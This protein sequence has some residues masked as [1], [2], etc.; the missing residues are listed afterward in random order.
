MTQSRTATIQIA[1]YKISA[2]EL[3]LALAMPTYRQMA[4]EITCTRLSAPG[5]HLLLTTAYG[6]ALQDRGG[7]ITLVTEG[8][9]PQARTTLIRA[10]IR[11]CALKGAVSLT[12]QDGDVDLLKDI[13]A[14]ADKLGLNQKLPPGIPAGD[15]ALEAPSAIHVMKSL[16]LPFVRNPAWR[17]RTPE[18]TEDA[19]ARKRLEALVAS[20]RGPLCLTGRGLRIK[21]DG[22]FSKV[23]GTADPA[24]EW[25]RAG[26]GQTALDDG[27][28]DQII[29]DAE[30]EHAG[31]P[32]TP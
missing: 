30:I 24:N 5:D 17:A 1:A 16:Y 4:A 7:S 25:R 19:P 29:E 26:I 15:K 12:P 9:S 28:M 31:I 22:D 14:I 23:G 6:G 27:A 20:F 2:H 11:L 13:M 18:M 21:I 10:A 3:G 32:Y 8:D